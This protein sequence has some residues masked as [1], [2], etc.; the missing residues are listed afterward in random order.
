MWY[1]AEPSAPGA[2]P[3]RPAIRTLKWTPEQVAE[4]AGFSI[5][6]EYVGH[7]IGTAMHEAPEVPNYR[8]PR[9][10]RHRIRSGLVVAIEPMV[11]IGSPE[12]EVLDDG[13]TVVTVDGRRAAHFE[14]TI[15]A[16]DNGPQ[17]LTLP[18]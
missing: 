11:T 12:T 17:V 16:T 2:A 13:W 15:A 4:A 14:H 10:R 9:G 1:P 7:G 6:R 8:T 3:N 18:A 5:V